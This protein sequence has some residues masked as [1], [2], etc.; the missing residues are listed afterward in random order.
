MKIASMMVRIM[1]TR[2]M[3]RSRKYFRRNE[4]VMSGISRF[5]RANPGVSLIPFCDYGGDLLT[6]SNKPCQALAKLTDFQV[7][8]WGRS[9]S[10]V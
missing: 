9:E 8:L 7:G 6:C 5:S 4:R 1:M 10:L 2:L 3:G